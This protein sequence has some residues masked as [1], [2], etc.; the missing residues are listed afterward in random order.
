[1]PS[2]IRD[3]KPEPPLSGAVAQSAIDTV[4]ANSLAGLAQREIERMIVE[5]ELPAGSRLNSAEIA[6][7]LGVSRAPVREAIRALDEAGLVRVEKNRG[8]FVREVTLEEADAIYEV[9]AALEGL[10]GKLAAQRIQPGEVDRLR[11]IVRKMASVDLRRKPEAYY[12]LNVTF[13]EVLIGAARNRP[14]ATHYRRVVNELDLYRRETISR[15][16][17]HISISTREHHAIVEAVAAGDAV[18]AER[19]LFDHVIRS[20]ERLHH[21]LRAATSGTGTH[22]PSKGAARAP[23]TLRKAN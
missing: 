9:R 13:H 17:D 19:L 20:R 21:A 11:A 18:S 7:K 23:S 14:L 4:R 2:I 1:M 5:G 12:L 16:N 10:I 3:V 15:V 8:I 22:P 6:E